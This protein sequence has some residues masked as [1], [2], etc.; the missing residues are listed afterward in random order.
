MACGLPILSGNNV[1]A[2][3][4]LVDEGINGWTFDSEN[5]EEISAVMQRMVMKSGS[6]GILVGLGES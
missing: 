2:A 1:G 4:K 5:V 3:E 6:S